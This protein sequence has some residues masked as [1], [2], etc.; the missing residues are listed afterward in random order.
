MAS[1]QFPIY[2]NEKYRHLIIE[3]QTEIIKF[4]GKSGQMGDYVAE[5][6][7]FYLLN[8]K[9]FPEKIGKE[10]HTFSNLS[11]TQQRING[12][13]EHFGES[14]K[15]IS[16]KGLDYDTFR[17]YLKAYFKKS[18]KTLKQ[19]ENEILT[20]SLWS[21]INILGTRKKI[22]LHRNSN[23]YDFLKRFDETLNYYYSGIKPTKQEIEIIKQIKKEL[24]PNKENI[25]VKEEAKDEAN[26]LFGGLEYEQ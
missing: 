7:E 9:H 13:I 16:N 20:G 10:K 2:L 12:F 22:V 24:L 17:I 23:I 8:L 25:E 15:P 5:A 18:D 1:Y 3:F 19:Y 11:K 26:E 4:E 6:L 21:I 14:L